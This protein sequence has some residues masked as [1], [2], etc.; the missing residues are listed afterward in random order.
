MESFDL[1]FLNTKVDNQ[2]L[3]LVRKSNRIFEMNL[4]KEFKGRIE[5]NNLYKKSFKDTAI[6]IG[7]VMFV[8]FA[9]LILFAGCGGTSPV[10]TWTL[11]RLVVDGVTYTADSQ[12]KGDYASA[13]EN[14][15]ILNEDNTGSIK[16]DADAETDATWTQ[17]DSAITITSDEQDL[18]FTLNGTELIYRP[19]DTISYFYKKS[20]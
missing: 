3:L 8:F 11:D 9:S 10:G 13:F 15:I 17:T 20:S 19:T 7:A 16:L 18:T 2:I 14:E 5:M 12:D 4:I 6:V 1:S